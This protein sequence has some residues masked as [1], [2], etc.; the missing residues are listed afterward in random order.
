MEDVV[1]QVVPNHTR[2]DEKLQAARPRESQMLHRADRPGGIDHEEGHQ[3]DQH[4]ATTPKK[5]PDTSPRRR[6]E[7]SSQTITGG[8]AGRMATGSNSPSSAE[9]TKNEG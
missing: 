6:V 4:D 3:D 2:L 5:K 9:L 7:S 8:T 1:A